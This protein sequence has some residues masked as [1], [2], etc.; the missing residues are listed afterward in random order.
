[1]FYNFSDALRIL[2]VHRFGGWYSDLD[3]VFLKSLNNKT[4]PMKNLVASDNWGNTIA[5]GLFHNDADHVFLSTAIKLF[6]RIFINGKYVSS[7]PSV[8]TKSLEVLCMQ[9][10]AEIMQYNSIS[11]KMRNCSGM[12]VA[13]SKL[14]FPYDWFHHV[15]LAESKPK[16]YWD[17]LLYT[18]PSPRD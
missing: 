5:N 18:S 11:H 9:P 2:L 14:F 8:F 12:T 15:E 13:D 16:Q 4:N 10:I 3:V 1:M 7:G 17:C 6:D